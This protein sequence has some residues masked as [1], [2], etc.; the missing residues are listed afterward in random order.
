MVKAAIPHHPLEHPLEILRSAL[1][2]AA[3]VLPNSYILRRVKAVGSE[4]VIG[5]R[6][7]N[8]FTKGISRELKGDHYD[9]LANA[10]VRSRLGRAL[11]FPDSAQ[12]PRVDDLLDILSTGKLLCPTGLNF[13]G[14]Y[15]MYYGS[16]VKNNRYGIRVIEVTAND[17]HFLTVTDSIKDFLKDKGRVLVSHGLLTFFEKCPQILLLPYE[18]NET[19]RGVTLMAGNP[20]FVDEH[21]NVERITGT[22]LTMTETGT[23]ALRHWMMLTEPNQKSDDMIAESGA[24]TSGELREPARRRHRE[25]FDQLKASLSETAPDPM[26]SWKALRPPRRR[27]N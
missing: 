19:K 13:S 8:N 9:Q 14:R 21:G 2:Q 6:G 16:Y 10:W 11:R 15:Y 18:F 17:D 5:A 1:Q 25:A 3:D 7:L 23:M 4:K 24:F 22:F 12:R 26:T 27:R 20:P